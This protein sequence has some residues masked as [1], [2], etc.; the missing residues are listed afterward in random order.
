MPVS[1]PFIQAKIRTLCLSQYLSQDLFLTDTHALAQTIFFP[2]ISIVSNF[3][4]SC[5]NR[6]QQ[7]S[8]KVVVKME[9][10]Q[11][12]KTS[13]VKIPLQSAKK[14]CIQM[15]R[16]DTVLNTSEKRQNSHFSTV[17]LFKTP[18]QPIQPN[19]GTSEPPHTP[20]TPDRELAGLKW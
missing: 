5:R 1:K 12:S 9:A 8:G 17:L 15:R 16:R 11:L 7:S 19:G 13:G 18:V 14:P 6:R 20:C 10:S 4:E 2:Q 3:S